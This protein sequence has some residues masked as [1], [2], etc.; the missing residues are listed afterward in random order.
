[1]I[2]DDECG[3]IKEEVFMDNFLS[4]LEFIMELKN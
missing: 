1:M 4:P 3:G 2:M